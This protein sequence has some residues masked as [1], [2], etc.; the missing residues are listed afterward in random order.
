MCDLKKILDRGVEGFEPTT[1][2][3]EGTRR[4]LRRR[5]RNRRALSGA[6]AIALALG[7]A[8]GLWASLEHRTPV[9][10]AVGSGTILT[11]LVHEIVSLEA[12][13]NESLRQLKDAQAR[14]T[15]AEKGIGGLFDLQ[16]DA[17]GPP[18][19][20]PASPIS[21][22]AM[23]GELAIATSVVHSLELS[24][25]DLATRIDALV[26]QLP[27]MHGRAIHIEVL[28]R[29]A[30]TDAMR[31]VV[32]DQGLYILQGTLTG[33]R[34]SLADPVTGEIIRSTEITG[35]GAPTDMAVAFGSVWVCTNYF[36]SGVQ[37]SNVGIDRLDSITLQRVAHIP[38]PAGF[39]VIRATSGA[40]WALETDISR[41][42]P[43]TN[44][45][46]QTLK[47][48]D[49]P[50]SIETFDT[51]SDRL[52][53]VL[54]GDTPAGTMLVTVDA[55]TGTVLRSDQVDPGAL[56]AWLTSANDQLALI[57]LASTLQMPTD[58]WLLAVR[59]GRLVS[60][61]QIRVTSL[62]VAAAN[63]DGSG[64]IGQFDGGVTS[65]GS[66]GKPRGALTIQFVNAIA[67]RPDGTA[68]VA[69][70]TSIAVVVYRPGF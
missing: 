8:G 10:P 16:H 24:L 3:F 65:I 58:G 27:L 17:G 64:W 54:G 62:I 28:R 63:P 12:Q 51:T 11:Q 9:R 19:S 20:G 2:W 26:V 39:E 13:Y 61:T 69:T 25:Q 52:M 21:M 48:P 32:T 56:S 5:Q 7:T 68:Y 66:D 43:T 41:I 53:V 34:V 1:D 33:Y 50:A 55:G 42:D 14:V 37:H 67:A 47:L 15:A 6:L 22:G 23:R 30:I 57:L 44:S 29:L 35:S 31:A 40:V 36:P 45:L 70:Q 46:T 38:S 49:S 60:R 59:D 4:H 18:N